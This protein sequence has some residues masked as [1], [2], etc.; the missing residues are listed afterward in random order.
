MIMPSKNDRSKLWLIQY[1]PGARL[2]SRPVSAPQKAIAISA[3][4]Q[5]ELDGRPII[6]VLGP[7]PGAG[8]VGQMG[9]APASVL[10]LAPS[11][12]VQMLEHGTVSFAP[13]VLTP[14]GR[15]T[16]TS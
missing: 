2:V 1:G 8:V 14:A 10:G 4:N 15:L 16:F 12:S 11:D 3:L 6:L 7:H 9:A 5:V 13:V